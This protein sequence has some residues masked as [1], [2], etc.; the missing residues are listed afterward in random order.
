MDTVNDKRKFFME[1][2]NLEPSDWDIKEEGLWLPESAKMIIENVDAMLNELT[3][4]MTNKGT[5]L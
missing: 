2:E 4:K 1:E 5:K 3:N